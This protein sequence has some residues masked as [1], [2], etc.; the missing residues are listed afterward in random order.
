MK[1]QSQDFLKNCIRSFLKLCNEVTSLM[2]FGNSFHAL[3]PRNLKDRCP[4]A[5]RHL[6]KSKS[7]QFLVGR[8]WIWE[9]CLNLCDKWSG[10]PLFKHYFMH[11]DTVIIWVF[12]WRPTIIMILVPQRYGHISSGQEQFLLQSSEEVATSSSSSSIV[13]SVS[14]TVHYYRKKLKKHMHLCIYL[15]SYSPI[16][17]KVAFVMHDACSTFHSPRYVMEFAAC[18]FSLFGHFGAIMVAF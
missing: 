17:M 2:N 6:T 16:S 3:A 1:K 11:H 12:G 14:E 15:Y 7:L 9:R 4:V 5:R 8:L 10:A 13:P 18:I